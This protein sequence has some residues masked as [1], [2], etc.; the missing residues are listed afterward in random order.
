MKLIKQ[1]E[2]D[3][4]RLDFENR[5]TIMHHLS[6]FSKHYKSK[7]WDDACAQL[8]KV[9]EQIFADIANTTA[10][11]NNEEIPH[12][13][14][15]IQ[16]HEVLE[17]LKDKQFFN[18]YEVNWLK[19]FYGYISDKSTHPGILKKEEAV[20]KINIV[21]EILDSTLKKYLAWIENGYKFI[22]DTLPEFPLQTINTLSKAL[23]KKVDVSKH[24][25]PTV[26]LT[27]DSMTVGYKAKSKEDAEKFPV[28]VN[29]SVFSKS[30]DKFKKA[31]TGWESVEFDETELADVE[32]FLGDYL[33]KSKEVGEKIKLVISPSIPEKPMRLFI[34]G[35]DIGFDYILMKVEKAD[36][37][38]IY[39]NARTDDE[40][41]NF[42]LAFPI[43]NIASGGSFT[44]NINADKADVCQ[45]VKFENF[46][47]ILSDKQQITLKSLELDKI[48]FKATQIGVDKGELLSQRDLDFYED[49][50]FIQ[51]NTRIEIK[52]PK[53]ITGRDLYA[54]NRIKNIL[55]NQ[56]E[57]QSVNEIKFK[58]TKK[59]ILL[60]L[61]NPEGLSNIV[62][63]MQEIYYEKLFDLQIP[64]GKP[65]FTFKK[66]V[67]NRPRDNIK[68]ELEL[69][70]NDDDLYETILIPLPLKQK[71]AEVK[72]IP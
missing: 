56:K 10:K 20:P 9:L 17:Y 2:A 21:F 54:I 64:L 58:M 69:L 40:V 52:L 27:P 62:F 22:P 51:Q 12:K 45:L 55:N 63:R 68:H 65:E 33:V 42:K 43:K 71:N 16:N 13:H 7:K 61:N 29:I 39:L 26:T 5:A 8:R 1:I 36:E 72:Y 50:C 60:M 18:P 48:I 34:P 66:A 47:R 23:I 11:A 30:A 19:P 53:E 59:Q 37:N 31:L 25:D 28:R 57:K 14:I 24:Y 41:F 46:L 35:T 44:L 32:L 38:N 70:S 4:Q 6:R 15:S 49:L 67:F 3:V